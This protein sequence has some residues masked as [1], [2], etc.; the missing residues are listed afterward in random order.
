MLVCSMNI[1]WP[2]KFKPW[3]VPA[4]VGSIVVGDALTIELLYIASLCV[5]FESRL[6]EHVT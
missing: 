3:K 2:K 6:D 5:R 1:T 4:F